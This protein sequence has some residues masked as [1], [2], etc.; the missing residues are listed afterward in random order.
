MVFRKPFYFKEGDS[1]PYCP[2]CWEGKSQAVHLL[3]GATPGTY[4]CQ[5][6]KHSFSDGREDE[7]ESGF[8]TRR[9]GFGDDLDHDF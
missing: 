6:G 9:R 7:A 5:H 2:T 3:D 1:V 8:P 4:I